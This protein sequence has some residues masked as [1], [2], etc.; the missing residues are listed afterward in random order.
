MPGGRD[1]V[2]DERLNIGIC[3][4]LNFD[5]VYIVHGSLL[6]TYV[7]MYTVSLLRYNLSASR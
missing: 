3:P 5:L 2:P 4:P 7:Y 6:Y 1:G